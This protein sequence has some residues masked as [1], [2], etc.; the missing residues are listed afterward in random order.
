M[1]EMK[2]FDNFCLSEILEKFLSTV[3]V[4]DFEVLNSKGDL[5]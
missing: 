4:Y 2:K 3:K 5:R 1:L